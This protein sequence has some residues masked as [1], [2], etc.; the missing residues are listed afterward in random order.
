MRLRT[1]LEGIRD[2]VVCRDKKEGCK[3]IL[4]RFPCSSWSR[5][6]AA[7]CI[8]LGVLGVRGVAKEGTASRRFHKMKQC[9]STLFGVN[10][11]SQWERKCL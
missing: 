9:T 7:I 5:S 2:Y 8:T 3:Y 10:S 6:S 1:E 4:G 11:A